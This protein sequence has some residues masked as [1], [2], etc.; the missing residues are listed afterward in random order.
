MKHR[1]LMLHPMSRRLHADVAPMSRRCLA[2]FSADVAPMSRTMLRQYRA[3]FRAM[4]RRCHARCGADVV[5]HVP[6]NLWAI[7]DKHHRYKSLFL[8]DVLNNSEIVF[9]TLDEKKIL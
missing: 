7:S 1:R 4:M 3:R 9:R 2:R 5:L 8:P 6:A